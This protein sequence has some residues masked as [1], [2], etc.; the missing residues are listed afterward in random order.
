MI[1]YEKLVYEQK[2]ISPSVAEFLF[3]LN[4]DMGIRMLRSPTK[5]PRTAYNI[6]LL[7]SALIQAFVIGKALN[8]S[9]TDENFTIEDLKI[10]RSALDSLKTYWD[11]D[12]KSDLADELSAISFLISW[13]NCGIDEIIGDQNAISPITSAY[14]KYRSQASL[15]MLTEEQ[16]LNFIKALPLLRYTT[17]DLKEQRIIFDTDKEHIETKCVPFITFWDEQVSHTVAKQTD[18][19]YVFTSVDTSNSYDELIFNGIQ[20]NSLSADK[21]KTKSFRR[22]VTENESLKALCK[23]VGIK[24]DWFPLENSCCDLAFLTTLTEAFTSVVQMYWETNRKKLRTLDTA[25]KMCMLYEG[26]ELYSEVSE[27][28]REKKS[29]EKDCEKTFKKE[30]KEDLTEAEIKNFFMELFVNYG[31]YKSLY[32]LFRDGDKGNDSSG[33]FDMF[34]EY[35]KEKAVIDEEQKQAYTELCNNTIKQHEFKL[36]KITRKDCPRYVNRVREIEA[37]WRAYYALKAAGLTAEKLFTDREEILSIDNYLDMLRSSESDYKESL[38]EVLQLLN[39]FYGSLVD[40]ETSFNEE[41]YL[42]K[43]ELNKKSIYNLSIEQLFDIFIETVKKSQD[44]KIISELLGR[45]KICDWKKI[46]D[47]RDDILSA[48]ENKDSSVNEEQNLNKYVFVSYAHLDQQRVKDF[49]TRWKKLGYDIYWDKERFSNDPGSDWKA[50]AIK[51]IKNPSC[52]AVFWFLSKN[53]VN[54][55][56]ILTE[57]EVAE[58]QL[59]ERGLPPQKFI[60]PINLEDE[61]PET[62]LKPAANDENNPTRHFAGAFRRI[63][64]YDDVICAGYTEYEIIENCLKKR[65]IDDNDDS[66]QVEKLKLNSA[67]LEILNFFAFLKYN[68][69]VGN[70]KNGDGLAEHFEKHPDNDNQCVF[71]M[72]ISVKET[73]V[74]RDKITMA[75]YEVITGKERQNRNFNYILTSKQLNTDEYYYLPNIKNAAASDGSWVVEPFLVPH[76]LFS[77]QKPEDTK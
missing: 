77:K 27:K 11:V 15:G 23:I 2:L 62:Y 41:E 76:D 51:A 29:I 71:P 31:V 53:V 13:C 59:S 19:C 73:K 33:L 10:S 69:E 34:M 22:N 66:L 49:V 35:F 17:L 48:F 60:I 47:Y 21:P 57:I 45:K 64:R 24:A 26:S 39:V 63:L 3:N 12:E 43:I 14:S 44:N 36:E 56:Q 8:E 68:D 28:I 55:E 5:W 18:N 9:N 52:S 70:W 4:D 74:K 16:F 42:K 54:S 46:E 37:E 67:Q 40:L 61:L 65:L 50:E 20:L 72:V 30:L 1:T 32:C 75:A 7:Y 38:T 6:C 25:E 58:D